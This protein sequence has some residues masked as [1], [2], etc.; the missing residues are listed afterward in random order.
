MQIQ[1]SCNFEANICNCKC[2]LGSTHYKHIHVLCE[3]P[4]N[5]MVCYHWSITV[6]RHLSFLLRKNQTQVVQKDGNRSILLCLC[7]R[8]CVVRVNR[9]DASINTS[10]STRRV[11]LRRTG[12]HVGFLCLCLFLRRTYKPGLIQSTLFKTLS[13][14]T[15]LGTEYQKS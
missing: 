1:T 3:S 14:E 15:T 11:R 8:P 10:A 9:D 13:L 7:L 5:F 2:F 4:Y 6:S 12:L